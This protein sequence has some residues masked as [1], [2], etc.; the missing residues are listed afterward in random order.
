MLAWQ[1]PAV[2]IFMGLMW[3][4]ARVR[5]YQWRAVAQTYGG[6]PRLQR[7]ASRAV[8]TIVVTERVASGQPR[9]DRLRW[10]HYPGVRIA[11][12]EDGLAFSLI[13][14]FNIM[15]RHLFMP[16]D[17]MEIAPTA[18]AMWPDPVAIRMKRAPEIDIIVAR[19]TV[20]WLDKHSG[21]GPFCRSPI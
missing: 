15:C 11:V 16:Y 6:W 3:Y 21:T 4:S 7:L 9:Q 2:G 5:S 1:V 20:R 17:E 12:H 18:W 8:D 14:P 10:A 19:D 13:P